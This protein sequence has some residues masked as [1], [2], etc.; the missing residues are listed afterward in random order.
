MQHF[1]DSSFTPP[2]FCAILHVTFSH[3][4]MVHDFTINIIVM[5]DQLY[6]SLFTIY[7]YVVHIYM[8]RMY[9]ASKVT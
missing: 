1:A 6:L 7:V 5:C 3:S 2:T 4:Y 9:L 8:I